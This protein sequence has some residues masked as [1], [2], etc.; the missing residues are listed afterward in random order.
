MSQIQNGRG[1]Y[2]IMIDDPLRQK[3]ESETPIIDGGSVIQTMG[4][5]ERKT[6]RYYWI[7]TPQLQAE[8]VL[9]EEQGADGWIIDGVN[10]APIADPLDLYN[11]QVT[12]HRQV[13]A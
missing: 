7:T 4:Y 10:R 3:R 5:I 11:A 8:L 9:L 2:S 6:Y 1:M 13:S 12:M